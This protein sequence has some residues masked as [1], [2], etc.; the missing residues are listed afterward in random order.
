M[1]RLLLLSV[2]VLM[3]GVV[4]LGVACG[5]KTDADQVKDV[6]NGMYSAYNS[7]NYDKCLEYLDMT[8]MQAIIDMMGG[9]EAFEASMK[10]SMATERDTSGK[11]TVQKIE[12]IKISGTTATADVTTKDEDGTVN[13]DTLSFLKKGDDWKLDVASME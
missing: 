8:S 10:A 7:E 1:R 6:V 3:L 9:E 11:I 13:T 4:G 2:V 5:A 12:N